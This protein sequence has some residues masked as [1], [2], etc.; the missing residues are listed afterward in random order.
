MMH[1]HQ[2]GRTAL[3]QHQSRHVV[4]EA[5]RH[6]ATIASMSAE[7]K[8][9]LLRYE[10]NSLAPNSVRSY[11]SD[12]QVF[13]RWMATNYPD[14]VDLSQATWPMCVDWLQ[15]QVDSGLAQATL[16]RRWAFLRAH[17]CE[18]LKDP[19][20]ERE[21]TKVVKGLFK[22]VARE[23]VKGKTALM[24]D[25]ILAALQK[26]KSKTFDEEQQRMFLLWAFGTALRRSET[27]ATRWRHVKFCARGITVNIPHSKSGEKTISVN[28]KNTPLD[29]VAPL[30]AWQQRT[31]AGPDDFIFRAMDRQGELL[32]T[33]IGDK[34]M[35]RYVKTAAMSLNL[36]S[37]AFAPHS[38]RSGCLSSHA[39]AGATT[40]QLM[41]LS[42]HKS[43]SSLQHYLKG[44]GDF[45]H[46]L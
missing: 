41:Q 25:Q 46:G 22:A 8:E 12:H 28:R 3:V 1:P 17:L 27:A 2:R 32:N 10:L 11:E 45:Q 37:E 14:C 19:A 42:A 15:S 9:S 31:A 24:A 18:S 26:I 21:Y 44:V 35:T 33:K 16:Q 38:L 13:L 36:P 23:G 34:T 20:V 39:V 5:A 4:D 29:V 30:L 7:K 40:A 6:R 43:L